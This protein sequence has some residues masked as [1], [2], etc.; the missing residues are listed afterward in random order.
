MEYEIY[1][2]TKGTRWVN[3][4]NY[5]YALEHPV[6]DTCGDAHKDSYGKDNYY[7]DPERWPVLAAWLKAAEE[8]GVPARYAWTGIMNSLGHKGDKRPPWKPEKK[9]SYRK[10]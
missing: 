4:G 10:W 3:I 6:Q 8:V 2:T 1:T 5:A 9:N 7:A